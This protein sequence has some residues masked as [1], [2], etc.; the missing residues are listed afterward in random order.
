MK[1]TDKVFQSLDTWGNHPAYI[2]LLP[3]NS[4][5]YTSAEQ[6]KER[7]NE[8][9][10][11]LNKSGIQNNSIVALFL[12]NS[13]DFVSIFLALMDI[14]AKP[15]PV[16]LA[17]RKIELDEIFSNS[18]FHAVI[19][20]EQLLPLIVPYLKKKIVIIRS[21]GKLKLHQTGKNKYE[22]AEIDDGI[23]SINYTYRGYGYPLGAM[24]PHSQYLIGAEVLVKGLKPKPGE[25]MLVILPFYYIFPLI[26]CLFVPL[27][28]KMTSI[29]S[30]TVNPLKLFKYIPQYKINI[31]TA[32]PEIY[33]LLFNCRE[34]STDLS[35]LKA[36]VSGGSTLTKE[37]YQIIKEAFN[38]ELLHGYGLTEFTPLSRNI[39]RQAKAGTIGPFCDGIDYK[40]SSANKNGEGEILIKNPYMTKSYYRRNKET[41]EAFKDDWFQTGDIG[42]IEDDHLLFI[43]EKKNTR[44]LKGN[45]IDLEEVK[46]AI[47]SYPKIKDAIIEFKDN[48]LSAGIKMD[49]NK[50]M[51]D[52]YINIK[53]FLGEIIAVYKIPKLMNLI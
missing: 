28:Y 44:K 48:T 9:K 6:L 21:N 1:I 39:R 40:I 35:S 15:I 42:R 43:K 33:E 27:L 29:L 13:V 18:E 31:I 45:M 25:N 7:I 51:K 36:F 53:K 24:V 52:E 50:D 12:G 30:L 32:I 19:A 46:K 41:Q 38:I 5:V 20:E 8:G 22:P 23:A 17:Y 2:E 34:E 37:K 4:H 47:L 26:G 14:G 11:F 16:N 10:K 3:D 49:T